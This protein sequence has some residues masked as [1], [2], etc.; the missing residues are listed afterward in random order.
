MPADQLEDYNNGERQEDYA[1]E[2]PD[3]EGLVAIG[4]I[5]VTGVVRH[6]F[7]TPGC[8]CSGGQG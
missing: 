1:N 7:E 2:E 5:L 8:A 4:P 3:G 6:G